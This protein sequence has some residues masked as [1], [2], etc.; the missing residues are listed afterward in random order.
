MN[1]TINIE[2][3]LTQDEIKEECRCAIRNSVYEMFCAKESDVDRLISNLGYEFI[4]E[5]VSEAIG[6]D[7]ENAIAEKVAELIKDDSSIR[8]EMWRKNDAWNRTESPAT[9]ILH[10]AIEDNEQLMRERVHDAIVN[11]EFPDVRE[12]MYDIACEVV[13]EKLFGE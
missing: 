5:A 4:F 12:A 3:Y 2:D 11:F 8:Y 10:K 6:K 7:A 9:K 13:S 1:V